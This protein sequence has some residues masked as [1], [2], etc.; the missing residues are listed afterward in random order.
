MGAKDN[1][2]VADESLLKVASDLALQRQ[3]IR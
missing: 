3:W 2:Q 1:R